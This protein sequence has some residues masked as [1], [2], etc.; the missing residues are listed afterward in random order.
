MIVTPAADEVCL[1]KGCFESVRQHAQQRRRSI[2][3]ERSPE[4]IEPVHPEAENSKRSLQI[5]EGAKG[6]AQMRFHAGAGGEAC[7]LVDCACVFRAGGAMIEIDRWRIFKSLD[8]TD[9]RAVNVAQRN[10]AH[11]YRN[12]MPGFVLQE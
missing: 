7:D 2:A 3:A 1:P 4:M 8:R 5:C 9:D 10:S 6:C 11:S 12:F